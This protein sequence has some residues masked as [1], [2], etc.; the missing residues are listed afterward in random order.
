MLIGIQ[1]WTCLSGRWRN[2]GQSGGSHVSSGGWGLGRSPNEHVCGHMGRIHKVVFIWRPTVS[3]LIDGLATL[4]TSLN[5]FKVN[6]FEQIYVKEG[7]GW[8]FPM[9]YWTEFM[10]SNSCHVWWIWLYPRW[11]SGLS[12]TESRIS[13][14]RVPISTWSIWFKGWEKLWIKIICKNF[15]T[16][17]GN[18]NSF[19]IPADISVH[20]GR[21]V[22]DKES[23]VH[24]QGLGSVHGA[25]VAQ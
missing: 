5:R 17:F 14:F 7:W 24:C 12:S 9:C 18:K 22:N 2:R 20:G 8:E 16:F 15:G 23:I 3:L 19:S 25:G 6:K 10:D 13:N 21:I 1:V 11:Q 4:A